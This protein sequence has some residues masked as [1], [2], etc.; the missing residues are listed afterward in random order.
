M[1]QISSRRLAAFETGVFAAMNEKKEARVKAGLP[2]YNLSIGTPDFKPAP[3]VMKALSDAALYPE[4]YKYALTDREPLLD[5]VVAYYKN[6]FGTEIGADEIMT[7]YGT[8]DGIG[9]IGMAL[10]DEGDLALLPDPGYPIFDAGTRLG[11]AT[12]VYYPLN[13]ENNFLPDLSGVDEATLAKVKYIILSYPSNPTGAIAPKSMYEDM[14]RWAKAHDILIINDNAYSDIIYDGAESFSFLSLPGAKEVGVE[15]FSLSKSF[16]LTGARVSF[17]IGR[18]DV[19]DA[20]KKLKSQIDFGMFLPI[21]A[22]AVAA[23]T[24]PLDMVKQQQAD[25][26][27]RRDA[28]CG[29]LREIGWDVPDAKGTMF[30]WA[31]LPPK[32]ESSMQ[33]CEVLMEKTGVIATPGAAFGPNGE[34]YVRFALVQPPENLKNICRLI[35]EADII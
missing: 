29:G 25:Y 26:Q 34:G 33:F 35:K 3:H 12:P 10:C 32:Y 28:L 27:A 1:A 13:A 15:F 19:V 4:N 8:Q 31:K 5:A 20:M 2:V 23:L 6:R 30:V 7:V 14:I 24:G 18:K 16:N 21:Q 22:A 17:L 11:G 9:H